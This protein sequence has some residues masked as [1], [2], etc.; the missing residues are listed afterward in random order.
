MTALALAI[1]AVTIGFSFADLAVLRGLPVADPERTVFI[2]GVSPRQ[3]DPAAALSTPELLDY[4]DRATTVTAMAGMATRPVSFVHEQVASAIHVH[5]ITGDFTA[6]WGLRPALGRLIQPGDDAPGGTGVVVLAHSF[7]Q[8]EFG[9]APDVVGRAVRIGG[10]PHEV[11]GVMPAD[12]EFGSLAAASAWVPLP[13]ERGGARDERR[14]RVTARLA[15]GVSAA[16]AAAEFASI[17]EALAEEHPETSGGW[18]ARAVPIAE[19]VGDASFWAVLTL[20]LLTVGTVMAIACANVAG[21]LLARATARQREFAIRLALGA[22]RG[23]MLR[24]M[25]VEGL[26]LSLAAGAGGLLV[27][28]GGLRVLRSVDADP[29][30]QQ[31]VIDGHELVLVA[32]LAL[33]APMAFSLA[34]AFRAGRQDL[35]TVLHAG[36]PR[37]GTQASGGRHALVVVQLVMAVVLITIAGLAV[38]T[39]VHLSQ[40]PSGVDASQLLA[41]GLTLDP[42]DFPDDQRLRQATDTFREGIAEVGGVTNVSVMEALPVTGAER[43]V[44]FAVDGDQPRTED[45]PSAIVLGVEAASFDTLGVPL[46]AGR[47]FTRAEVREAAPVALVSDALAERHF[48]GRDAALGRMVRVLGEEEPPRRRI[49]GV[50]GDVRESNPTRGM[51]ARLWVPRTPSRSVAVVVRTAGEPT[52]VAAGVRQ[53]MRTMASTLPLE[54]L[55]PFQAKIDRRGA[56]DRIVISMFTGFALLALAL[57]ATG[58]YAVVSFSVARR[59][60]EFG[61]RVALGARTVDVL[62]LVMGQAFRLMAVGLAAGLALG[63]LATRAMAGMF[64]GVTPAD[65]LN[66][67]AVMA[68][69]ILLTLA[70]SVVPAWR[71]ARV[72]PVRALRAE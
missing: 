7:W 70:A 64:Y 19:G 30:F 29:V 49:V 51:P 63:L 58:L 31:L 10:R 33:M 57:A 26:V 36:G 18:S 17:A 3:D 11:V 54:S 52:A 5:E 40:V 6:I 24:Q 12:M 13:L 4:R 35:R 71:A 8:R 43:R 32:V 46:V 23:R 27:A 21:I 25:L 45:A 60:A 41:F 22:A 42:V 44:P 28:E 72:D 67:M 62:S 55:E 56:S 68:L 66:V 34:P 69:L 14:L 9:G 16:A 2:Y 65:P 50:T 38:R 61:T 53:A 48:G 37:G 59:R 1:G 39:A 15:D 20:L 47:V